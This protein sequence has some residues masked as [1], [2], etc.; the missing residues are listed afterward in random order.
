[1]RT[2]NKEIINEIHQIRRM[3]G[4]K[5]NNN[6]LTEA[7]VGGGIL[8]DIIGLL[9]KKT[10]DD[11]LALGFKNAD[12]VLTFVREFP[13]SSI[14]RQSEIVGDLIVLLGDS[15][16]TNLTKQLLDDKSSYI[17]GIVSDRVSYYEEMAK[18]YPNVPP[19]E[20]AKSMK[21]DMLK[22]FQG[23]DPKVESL[24]KKI[25]QE[26]GERVRN[27]VSKNTTTDVVDNTDKIF[28]IHNELAQANAIDEM[29]TIY[30]K[31]ADWEKLT[32]KDKNGFEE[33]VR[34]NKSKTPA[35]MASDTEL[36]FLSRLKSSTLT[37]EQRAKYWNIFKNMHWTLKVGTI[38]A[39]SGIFS[40]P[41]LYLLGFIGGRAYSA[42]D[43]EEL[44]KGFKT[45]SEEEMK[46][47]ETTG[48]CPG[49]EKFIKEV[50]ISYGE[51]YDASKLG[52]F[53]TKTCAGTYDE[54]TYTWDGTTFK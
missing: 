36:E 39:I 47:T 17:G 34:A 49:N 24:V 11:L 40:V 35:Q 41:T 9:A 31:K 33:F 13:N 30:K 2:N 29:L 23:A 28:K 21:D 48:N 37:K 38:L 44:K 14:T 27:T 42:V 7:V 16:L 15:G 43:L 50:K 22:A 6:L 54:V 10:P 51:L 53:D 20:F 26:S 32:S 3:M 1:M 8:D 46:N 45:G 4:L 19:D 5:T 18:K 25:E 52:D 12:E